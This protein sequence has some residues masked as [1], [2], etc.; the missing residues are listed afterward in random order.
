MKEIKFEATNDYL[1][2]QL[3]AADATIARLEEERAQ[4]HR[5]IAQAGQ[6][7]AAQKP[8]IVAATALVEHRK[9][10]ARI[11]TDNAVEYVRRAAE[12]A[13]ALDA[14]VEEST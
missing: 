11:T 7:L 9:A 10:G 6:K 3:A 4:C 13:D 2:T 8:I 1:R 12:L 5:L 14:A